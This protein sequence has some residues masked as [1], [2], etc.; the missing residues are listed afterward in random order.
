M[1][2]RTDNDKVC[3]YTNMPTTKKSMQQNCLDSKQSIMM[4]IPLP[5][6]EYENNL[7]VITT[8]KPVK[9]ALI[10]CA[11]VKLIVARHMDEEI[12]KLNKNIISDGHSLQVD[13]KH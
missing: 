13:I 9:N 4:N 11:K 5:K 8:N 1:N 7:S 3:A 10:L 2:E 6:I 12:S